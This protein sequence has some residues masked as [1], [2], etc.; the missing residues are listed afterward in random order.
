MISVIE[1]Y[2]NHI[3][4][5]VTQLWKRYGQIVMV[6][7]V[8][9]IVASTLKRTIYEFNRLLFE[10]GMRGANDLGLRYDEVQVWFSG[11]PVYGEM[12]GAMYPPASYTMLFPFLHYPSFTLARWIWLVVIL[13]SLAGIIYFFI[14]E[15]KATSIIER[16]LIGIMVIAMYGT[17][18]TIGNGQLT[19]LILVG[20]V[21]GFVLMNKSEGKWNQELLA[22][23]L[24]ILTLIKPT[25]SLP[26]M[27]LLLFPRVQFRMILIIGFGYLALALL[28]T[29]FQ[30]GNLIDLHRDW[31]SRGVEGAAWSSA[32]G[33]GDL[34][35][36]A[37]KINKV[38][39]AVGG[40]MGYGNIHNWLGALGLSKW[41]FSVS[42]L[43]LLIT[44]IWVYLHRNLDLWIL[45]GVIA[46]ISRLWTY[47]LV[48]DD[49]L[50]LIPVLALLRLI[51][52]NN[53]SNLDQMLTGLLLAITIFGFL[54]P[55]KFLSYAPYDT[56]FK[57]GQ[58][59][60]WLMMLI[61]L[62]YQGWKQRS[63]RRSSF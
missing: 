29:F 1:E 15:S 34:A 45:L 8:I 35:I 27:W 18:V 43:M 56:Y 5:I 61:F 3:T 40:S 60:I 2:L 22:G 6:I 13:V 49:M 58:L 37:S 21:A 51:K 39:V 33:G 25:L 50:I 63:L 32:G 44:G 23:G 59:S 19:T 14:K 10:R 12:K 36:K 24:I 38:N 57:I 55:P 52:Q 54:V 17:G 41:N 9:F 7:A 31:L 28:A 26:F 62:I 48:Y 4:T 47:H 53:I 20:I 11:E 16:V 46:I 30:D 42:M